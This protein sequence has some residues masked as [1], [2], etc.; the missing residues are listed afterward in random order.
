MGAYGYTYKL[1]I[2]FGHLGTYAHALADV[3]N[4][5][6]DDF[7]VNIGFTDPYGEVAPPSKLTFR[8][9]NGDRKLNP[10]DTTSP[11]YGLITKGT[12]VKYTHSYN[13]TVY[14]T[15]IGKISRIRPIVEPFEN[16][17]NW[18]EITAEDPMNQLLDAQILPTLQT[19]ILI[20]NA[21]ESI[22][23]NALSSVIYPYPSSWSVLDVSA[24]DTAKLLDQDLYMSSASGVTLPYV[25]D[26][27]S[28]RYHTV[29]ARSMIAD[30]MSAEVGGRF[31]WNGQKFEF[32]DRYFAVTSALDTPAL[33]FEASDIYKGDYRLGDDLQN[34]VTATF[35]PRAV[36]T[37][38]SII[39]TLERVVS[40]GGGQSRVITCQYRD[41]D[42]QTARIGALNVLD[43]VSGTDFV[44]NSA[45]DGSG[46]N[47]TSDIVA[48][49]QV[50]AQNAKITL[51][52]TGANTAHITT[53]Q[54]RGTPLFTYERETVNAVDAQ[55]INDN[56]RYPRSY[57]F[58]LIAD[59]ETAQGFA[60]IQV[61]RFKDQFARFHTVT[62][63]ANDSLKLLKNTVTIGQ[64][65]TITDYTATKHVREY[66]VT[67]IQHKANASSKRHETTFTLSPIARETYWTLG[68]AGLSE[69]D[70]TAVIGL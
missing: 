29:G 33:A 14:F 19:D 42:N 68:V 53:L 65:V 46:T 18:L 59:E 43:P 22:V 28:D 52:N 3:T 55:S 24:L 40:I 4:R 57:Q 31:F 45:S 9:N 66:A 30:L 26:N 1:L 16:G 13:S 47:V 70:S 20:H 15:W 62:F 48:A 5:W 56:G 32:Q 67:G 64:T 39:Y 54:L 51:V 44:A 11:Y 50:F 49:I 6:R 25:G 37:A 58:K 12:L 36:G 23:E 35:Q 17:D 38:A 60:N 34:D 27:A 41:P 10:D 2:D 61:A 69:L 7:S 21:L 8:L 63:V